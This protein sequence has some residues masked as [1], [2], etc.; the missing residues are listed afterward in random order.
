[1]IARYGFAIALCCLL[2]ALAGCNKTGEQATPQ[3][4][5][6]ETAMSE[7]FQY[8]FRVDPMMWIN[9]SD[10]VQAAQVRAL[11]LNKP[12]DGDDAI[13]AAEV[14]RILATQNPDGQRFRKGSCCG[15]LR[16]DLRGIWGVSRF[17]V[18]F[19]V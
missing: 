19:R 17:A 3:G 18:G 5:T 1:M 7:Q 10:S 6:E 11:L 2:A 13:L 15:V 12:K 8:G 16:N 14:D 9:E 4:Q